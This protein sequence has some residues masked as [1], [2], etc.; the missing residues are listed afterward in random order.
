MGTPYF[1]SER[2]MEVL[3]SPYFPPLAENIIV[4]AEPLTCIGTKP[5][6]SQNVSSSLATLTLCDHL[7]RLPFGQ[8]PSPRGEGFATLALVQSSSLVTETL[9]H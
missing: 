7:I 9:T 2:W 6:L 4:L 1:Y 5:H 3:E 8:P